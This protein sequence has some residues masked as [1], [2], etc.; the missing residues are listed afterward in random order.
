MEPSHEPKVIS[1]APSFFLTNDGS[2][3][4]CQGCEKAEFYLG[5]IWDISLTDAF[6]TA[7]FK[8]VR[9]RV[10]KNNMYK[11]RECELR[12]TCVSEGRP[13]V[14]RISDN[15]KQNCINRMFVQSLAN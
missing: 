5:N 8:A 14:E 7:P 3:Y 15:C 13:C 11:C 6:K 2:I 4:P 9:R 10:I 12:Y 1:C